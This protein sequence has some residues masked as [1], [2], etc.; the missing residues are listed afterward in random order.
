MHPTTAPHA[1]AR[2]SRLRG[3]T[4]LVA[5]A[6]L[7]VCAAAP[8]AAGEWKLSVTPYAWATD[9]GVDVAID[10]DA[11]IDA[12]IDVMDLLEDVETIAQGRFE[13]QRG[14]HGV[15]FD[16]FD[17][18][19]ADDES[20]VAL[21]SGIG[22]EAVLGSEMGMTIIEAGG[23][24]DPRGDQRGFTLFY[25]TR[26]LA[27]RAEIS[28]RIEGENAADTRASYELDDTL[29]DGLIGVRYVRALST[30]WSLVMRA[31]LSAGGTELTWSAGPAISYA[32]GEDQRYAITAGYRHLVVDFDTEEAVDAEMALS[33]FLAGLRITF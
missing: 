10:D 11:L 13:A 1:S 4:A 27:E 9:V 5:L 19:L 30:R 3:A 14:E 26:I 23:L 6:A 7:P 24:Y 29:A 18:Q 21:P 12:E 25:G 16:L 31:D 32:F 15:M 17:V 8:V 2:A 28:A 20:R 22:G 33:G